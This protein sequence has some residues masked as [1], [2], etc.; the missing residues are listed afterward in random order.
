MN[1]KNER[2][3]HTIPGKGTFRACLG[4]VADQP[5]NSA[6]GKI[7]GKFSKW[8]RIPSNIQDF[9]QLLKPGINTY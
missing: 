9:N 1:Y 6:E 2:A 3:V 4:D 5:G 8:F 7:K